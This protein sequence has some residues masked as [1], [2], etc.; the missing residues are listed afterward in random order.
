MSGVGEKAELLR[1]GA[2]VRAEEI[3]THVNR[4]DVSQKRWGHN[5]RLRELGRLH[6]RGGAFLLHLA[7]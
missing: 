7:R 1:R 2:C 6:G 5:V 4:H 3:D